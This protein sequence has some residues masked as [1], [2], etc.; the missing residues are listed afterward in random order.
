MPPI[1][2]AK[3]INMS[4]STTVNSQS[5]ADAV[6]YATSKGVICVA[7]SGNDGGKVLVYP[8]GDPGSI[9]VASTNSKDHRSIFTNYGVGSARMAAPGEALITTYPGGHY[10]GVWGTSFST[11]LVSGAA[12]LITQL[13]PHVTSSDLKDAFEHGHP[14]DDQ[15][16]GDARLDVLKCLSSWGIDY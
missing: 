10:A 4:F 2:G 11:A 6:H 16:G 14:V 7:S 15:G 3:V 12:A 9:G 5:L 13:H 8:A 1:H